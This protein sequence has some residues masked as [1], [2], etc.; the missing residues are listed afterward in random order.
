MISIP[1]FEFGFQNTPFYIY[2]SL[3]AFTVAPKFGSKNIHSR[4]EKLDFY[5][6]AW[7]SKKL[8]LFSWVS[9]W[10]ANK[11]RDDDLYL[12]SN[13]YQSGDDPIYKFKINESSTTVSSN[14][15]K[16]FCYYWHELNHYPCFFFFFLFDSYQGKKLNLMSSRY[17]F[18]YK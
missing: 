14:K 9:P 15:S 4:L 3:R 18:I 12:D 2:I 7:D 10:C 5:I 16:S 11:K 13:M 1:F 17:F 6:I 8:D